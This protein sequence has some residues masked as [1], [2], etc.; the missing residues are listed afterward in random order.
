MMNT[1]SGQAYRAA[2][3]IGALQD[4][5]FTGSPGKYVLTPKLPQELR[6]MTF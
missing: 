3:N 4:A 5:P 1:K 2:S 6:F